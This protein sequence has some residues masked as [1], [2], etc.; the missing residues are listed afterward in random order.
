MMVAQGSSGI[1]ERI[2]T[3]P[4]GAWAVLIAWGVVVGSVAWFMWLVRRKP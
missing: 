1:L 2:A 4:V 3:D